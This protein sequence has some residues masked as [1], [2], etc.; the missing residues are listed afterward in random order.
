MISSLPSCAG[1]SPRQSG[2]SSSATFG[3]AGSRAAIRCMV[4]G[5]MVEATAIDA[6][7]A[8]AAEH[9]ALA[10]HHRLDLLVEA[11]HDDDEVA[12]GRDR[13][14]RQRGAARRPRP[15]VSIAP[16]PTSKP[17]TVK[18]RRTRWRAIGS[19][20]LPSPIMPTRRMSFGVTAFSLLCACRLRRIRRWLRN[21][22]A[23]TVHGAR[24]S[25]KLSE[26]S[27]ASRN[28]ASKE[29]HVKRPFATLLAPALRRCEHSCHL[30][31][32]RAG[33]AQQAGA[34]RQHLRARRRRRLSRAHRR[35]QSL[36]RRSASSSSSRPAPA[37][38]ARSASTRS[39]RRRPTA[40]TSSS[41]TSPCWCWR[42]SA[43]RRLGY[44]PERDLTNIAYL[45]GS[46]IVLSVNSKSPIK[47]LADF[48]AYGKKSGKP[49]T[50]SSSGVGSSGHLF[51]ETFAQQ[52]RH[53]GRA[54]ALQGR[55][56]GPA[57]SR[58]RPHHVVGAD[59]DVVG[60][61]DPRRHAARDRRHRPRSAWPTIPTCR[62]SPSSATRSSTR[63]S[64]SRCRGPK[65]LPASILDRMNSE[66][67]KIMT[68]PAM[69]ERMRKEGM[70][71]EAMTPP[72]L[73]QLIEPRRASGVRRSRRRADAEVERLDAASSWPELRAG[74]HAFAIAWIPGLAAIR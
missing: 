60:R 6:A 58:R 40:T 17:A 47:T 44:H 26:F 10:E 36:E 3:D 46:P 37:R 7:V 38:P 23:A 59:R 65:G 72:Q 29:D 33:L 20:I 66:I 62:P 64:G 18:P 69:L 71:V 15:P 52:G 43:I 50:Y 70:V 2:M 31:C 12:R 19:P 57:R 45:G 1:P 5:A 56:A 24:P 73:Q 27:K 16:S 35:R 41:P 48:V 32:R 54:R 9:A 22:P 51:G 61:P 8:R 34:H 49:L 74:I 30:T 39:W 42:R 53:Q 68:A 63:R 13:L 25:R 4:C 11:D 28:V 14:R 55:G 21:D 67:N